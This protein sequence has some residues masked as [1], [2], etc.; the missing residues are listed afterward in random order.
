MSLTRVPTYK[1]VEA[2]GRWRGF[3]TIFFDM[4]FEENQQITGDDVFSLARKHDCPHVYF[5]VRSSFRQFDV[6]I[7]RPELIHRLSGDAGLMVTC[8]HVFGTASQIPPMAGGAR[9]RHLFTIQTGTYIGPLCPYDLRAFHVLNAELKIDTP[10]LTGVWSTDP[11][12][13]DLHYCADE[14]IS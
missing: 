6:C 1:G 3:D 14:E 13:I 8:E 10:L 11:Q 9:V 12:I 7:K 4:M 2:E 5:G